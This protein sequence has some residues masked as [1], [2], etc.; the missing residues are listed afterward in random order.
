MDLQIVIQGAD[1][2]AA[3]RFAVRR[4]GTQQGLHVVALLVEEVGALHDARP[5]V[6]IVRQLA[7]ARHAAGGEVHVVDQVLPVAQ[8][9]AV[10]RHGFGDHLV[11]ED[12]GNVPEPAAAP[13]FDSLR[14]QAASSARAPAA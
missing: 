14:Q 3:G 12:H 5:G 7:V 6:R 4:F 11:I 10:A 8:H 1:K 2:L 9:D 13:A